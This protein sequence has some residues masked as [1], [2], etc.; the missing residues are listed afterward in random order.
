MIINPRAFGALP[1]LADNTAAL[2]ASLDA[3]SP[4]D[5]WWLDPGIWRFDGRVGLELP[6]TGARLFGAG[7]VLKA[8]PENPKVEK[9]SKPTTKSN[10]RSGGTCLRVKA[11]GRRGRYE[12]RKTHTSKQKLRQSLLGNRLLPA[13]PRP[14][15][16]AQVRTAQP[17]FPYQARR[18]PQGVQWLGPRAFS[19]GVSSGDEVAR[20]GQETRMILL[21]L[22]LLG[23]CPLCQK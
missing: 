19:R 2:Q 18:H 7:S 16:V 13:L 3:L 10:Q 17:T 20:S 14:C 4:S 21:L 11:Q 22:L 23:P 6:R 15:L 5:T 1:E 9:A 8:T 12:P